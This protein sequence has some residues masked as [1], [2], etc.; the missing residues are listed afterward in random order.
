MSGT[1]PRTS[2]TPETEAVVQHKERIICLALCDM[3]SDTLNVDGRSHEDLNGAE[4][5]S[6][7]SDPVAQNVKTSVTQV[8]WSHWHEH[9]YITDYTIYMHLY[10]HAVY[11]PI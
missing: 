3:I 6:A 8:L 11:T 9:S 1:L 4:D 10:T 7:S 5:F 2:R